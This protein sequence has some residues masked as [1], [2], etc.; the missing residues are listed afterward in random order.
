MKRYNKIRYTIILAISILNT[1][2][3]AMAWKGLEIE[4]NDGDLVKLNLSDDLVL[5]FTPTHL[6]AN[7][8]KYDLE[9]PIGNIKDFNMNHDIVDLTSDVRLTQEESD[10]SFL[11]ERIILGTAKEV[12][13]YSLSGIP[14]Y[15]SKECKEIELTHLQPGVYV[16]KIDKLTFKVK[17]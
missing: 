11:K 16:I 4:Q 8:D 13:V 14:V 9:I 2:F 5:S 12:M 10:I 6:V 15:S 1:S 17:K 7:S 3:Q